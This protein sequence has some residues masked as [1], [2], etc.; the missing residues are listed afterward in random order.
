MKERVHL[1]RWKSPAG[2]AKFRALE[3][4]INRDLIAEHP[5]AIDVTTR[6][7]PT[8]AYR[9]DG[10]GTPTVF[11]HGAGG[12]SMMWAPYAEH[13]DGR[14]MYAIDTIGDVGRSQQEVAVEDA[15]DL[16][17]WLAETLHA[18]GIE[19][20]DLAGTSYGG[21]LAL[22]LAARRPELV[23]SLCLI[24]PAGVV[25][26]HMAKFMLWGLAT[27]FASLLPASLR[28]RAARILRTPWLE[29]K[30]V[31]RL[32]LIG[33]M[34]HRT[35]LLRPNRFTDEQMA[36]VTQPAL[37]IL[38]AKSEAF[39]TSASRARIEALVPNAEVEVIA[40]AGHAVAT[41]DIEHICARLTSL[42]ER[43]SAS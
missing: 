14:L 28:R 10:S 22:N 40:S 42:L 20:A 12:T 19:R 31:F 34:Q 27:L 33:Q 32:A 30:R 3:D 18:L 13:R 37:C 7:G 8:R 11:L 16:V 26:V 39:P 6:L 43:V 24:D 41:S 5:T 1:S 29:E 25:P 2:E 15:D 9:W 21:F 36:S 17:E 4:E 23:R 35:R 38:G